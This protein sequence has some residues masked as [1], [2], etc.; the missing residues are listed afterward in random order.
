ML[1]SPLSSPS[2]LLEM[3]TDFNF[4]RRY[5]ST[6]RSCEY[7]AAIM[8]HA[9]SNANKPMAVRPFPSHPFLPVVNPLPLLQVIFPHEAN[10]KKLASELSIS[11]DLSTLVQSSQIRDAVLKSL[12]AVGKKAGFKALEMLQTVVITDEEWTPQNG[13]MTAASKLNRP[14]I[15]KKFKAQIDV[16]PFPLPTFPLFHVL[17]LPALPSS[18]HPLPLRLPALLPTVPVTSGS[19]S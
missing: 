2:F 5:R 4:E 3:E 8:V 7:V 16:R 13:L 17:S 18:L 9:D 12:N 14:V 19:R 10:L 1:P 15:S 11:G 6:Y